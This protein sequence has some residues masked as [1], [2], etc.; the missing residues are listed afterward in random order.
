M[1]FY[2]ERCQET[3]DNE[4]VETETSS[5]SS[6]QYWTFYHSLSKCFLLETCNENDDPDAKSGKRDCPPGVITKAENGS[7]DGGFTAKLFQ[8]RPAR[9]FQSSREILLD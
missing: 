1:I 3:P 7:R 6:C 2:L 8:N 4:N 5:P 9:H